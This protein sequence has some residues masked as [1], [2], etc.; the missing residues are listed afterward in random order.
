MSAI[1]GARLS[2]KCD[3]GLR[4]QAIVAALLSDVF[5]GRRR[6]G[7]HLV[8]QDLADQFQ[9]SHTPIREA[10]IAL[11]GMGVIDL[12]PN[13]GA[14][15]RKVTASEIK[16][17]C[18]FRSLLECQA[19]RLACGRVNLKK[20]RELE[21]VLRRLVN[22]KK[23]L[24]ASFIRQARAVDTCLHD[25]IAE[26]CNNRFLAE[27][28]QRFKIL[29]RSFRDMAWDYD[30]AHND[31][32]RPSEEAREHLAIVEALQANK[33]REAAQAMS[34]HIRSG[35]KYWSR[36]IIRK[37]SLSRRPAGRPG[38]PKEYAI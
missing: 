14:V 6:A 1:P 16:D 7:E 3:H 32:Q 38:K 21:S 35:Y 13:R 2:L 36:A 4:R 34:R 18:Q 10:L 24:G 19:V 23:D 20:L 11:A 30:E 26:S 9:V 5:H 15:V 12:V 31:F 22:S 33:P 28:I 25:V 27:A 37:P 29:F 17:I 8:T